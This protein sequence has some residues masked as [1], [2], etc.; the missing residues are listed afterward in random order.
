MYAQNYLEFNVAEAYQ[1]VNFQ[2]R[3]SRR[4][5]FIQMR[6]KQNMGLIAPRSWPNRNSLPSLALPLLR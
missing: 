1:S 2:T 6:M 5:A 4:F 3:N